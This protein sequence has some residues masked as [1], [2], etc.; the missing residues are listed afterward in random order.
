MA[1]QGSWPAAC[2]G[3]RSR[4]PDADVWLGDDLQL[5]VSD[6]AMAVLETADLAGCEIEPA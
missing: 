3:S 1:E 6:R 4:T 2:A 5:C